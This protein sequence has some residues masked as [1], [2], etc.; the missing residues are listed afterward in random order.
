[1]IA[2]NDEILDKPELIVPHP[3][4]HQRAFVLLP[5]KEVAE[6]WQHPVLGATLDGLIAALPEDQQAQPMEKAEVV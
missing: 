5:M 1:M 2:Y 3:R 4:M 6:E